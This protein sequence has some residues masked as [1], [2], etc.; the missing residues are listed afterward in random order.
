VIDVCGDTSALREGATANALIC[1]TLFPPLFLVNFGV[2]KRSK[3]HMKVLVLGASGGTEQSAE[4]GR[5]VDQAVTP[6]R[7]NGSLE[8]TTAVLLARA[9]TR[10]WG[11]ALGCTVICAALA[12]V[13]G[14]ITW[15]NRLSGSA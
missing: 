3:S 1:R 6:F 11:A 14:W 12:I 13:V 10:L 7:G 2:H 15:R 8:L 4:I 9:P 5:R